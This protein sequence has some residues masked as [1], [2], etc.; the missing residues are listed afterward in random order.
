MFERWPLSR[1]IDPKNICADSSLSGCCRDVTTR[2]AAS[3]RYGLIRLAS[4]RTPGPLKSGYSQSFNLVGQLRDVNQRM[5]DCRI[6][7][8]PNPREVDHS[9]RSG[10]RFPR[11]CEVT[12]E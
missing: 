9:N 6:K 12:R 7:N 4:I 1:G 2:F 8:L 10:V 3:I 11:G 5:V